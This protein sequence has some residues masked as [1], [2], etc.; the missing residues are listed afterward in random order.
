MQHACGEDKWIGNFIVET[1]TACE[2]VD[3]SRID[4]EI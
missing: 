2:K 1:H 4:D 3:G